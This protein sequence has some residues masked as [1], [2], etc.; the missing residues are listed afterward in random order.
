LKEHH[1]GLDET[2]NGVWSLYLGPVL[3]GRIEERTM[4]VYE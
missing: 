1:D 4:K 3:P 2:V